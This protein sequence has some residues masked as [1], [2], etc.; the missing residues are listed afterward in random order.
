MINV[1][2]NVFNEYLEKLEGLTLE[3]ISPILDILSEDVQFKDPFNNVKGK[4]A[5][6]GIFEK[7]FTDTKYMDFKIHSKSFTENICLCT[8][9]LNFISSS[10]LITQKKIQI[11]GCS[12]ILLN[13]EQLICAHIDYWDSSILFSEIPIL[14]KIIKYLVNRVGLN[15]N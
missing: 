8:W 6:R 10:K 13:S 5:Y 3:K 2:E 4:A 15:N 7:A 12:E 11:K 9:T 14:G 1:K